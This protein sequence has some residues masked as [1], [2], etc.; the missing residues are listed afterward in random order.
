MEILSLNQP[1]FANKHPTLTSYHMTPYN[2]NLPPKT[3][4]RSTKFPQGNYTYA[5]TIQTLTLYYKANFQPPTK[6]MLL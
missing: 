2:R 1:I 5:V 3:L 4:R 6:A